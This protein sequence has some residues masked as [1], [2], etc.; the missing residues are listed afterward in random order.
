MPYPIKKSNIS[1]KAQIAAQRLR[2]SNQAFKDIQVKVSP[3]VS[4]YG[5]KGAVQFHS[6]GAKGP[7]GRVLNTTGKP[8]V[9]IYEG[10]MSDEQKTD[11]GI[12]GLIYG[13]AQHHLSDSDSEWKKMRDEVWNNRS[14]REKDFDRRKY[15]NL[16][17]SG[18]ENRSFED[19]ADMSWKDAHVRGYMNNNPEWMQIYNPK[20]KEV[21]E[22]MKSYIE[23]SKPMLSKKKV[24]IIKRKK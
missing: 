4:P 8:L 21:L 2:E 5:H 9:E 13:D 20:Q 11:E 19:W 22:K 16:V 3:G 15:D 23:P 12:K 1:K 6:P 10:A 14:S 7:D 18:E 17:K 24:N